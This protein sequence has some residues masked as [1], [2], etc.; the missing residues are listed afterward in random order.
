MMAICLIALVLLH[1]IIAAYV[2]GNGAAFEN[3]YASFYDWHRVY[4]YVAAI[5]WV[6]GLAYVVATLRAW[7]AKPHAV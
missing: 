6:A 1:P 4:L 2:D 3:G 7:S 5:Q